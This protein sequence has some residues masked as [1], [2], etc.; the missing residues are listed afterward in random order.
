VPAAEE[1]SDDSASWRG[2]WP[3]RGVEGRPAAVRAQEDETELIGPTTP[4]VEAALL[5]GTEQ[6]VGQLTQLGQRLSQRLDPLV[7]ARL[8]GAPRRRAVRRDVIA[9]DGANRSVERRAEAL[10]IE[11]PHDRLEV[12]HSRCSTTRFEE[13]SEEALLLVP[14]PTP[15]AT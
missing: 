14:C 15:A 2:R 13:R 12:A 1:A 6:R 5:V 11:R 4:R 3:E 9:R 7:Q 10:C 8:E